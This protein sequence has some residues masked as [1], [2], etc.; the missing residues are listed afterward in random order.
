MQRPA[1]HRRRSV[2]PERGSVRVPPAGSPSLLLDERACT[3]FARD[4]GVERDLRELQNL[5]IDN[6]LQ[7]YRPDD[8]RAAQDAFDEIVRRGADMQS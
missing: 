4:G 8:S 3:G 7:E 5:G 1:M 6:T 2:V